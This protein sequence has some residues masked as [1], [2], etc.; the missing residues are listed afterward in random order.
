MHTAPLPATVPSP[1]PSCA[2]LPPPGGTEK[3][4]RRGTVPPG[5]GP[6]LPSPQSGLAEARLGRCS[7][8]G[9]LCEP[10]VPQALG[11]SGSAQR[12]SR[13]VH[14]SPEARGPTSVPS[15]SLPWQNV[16]GQDPASEWKSQRLEG[17][18]GK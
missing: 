13:E 14:P 5:E 15:G 2:P 18:P 11:E 3:P 1:C 4:Y 12:S 16:G 9:H 6:G 8:K 10:G 17:G 7:L